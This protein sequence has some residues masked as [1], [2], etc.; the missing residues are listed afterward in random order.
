METCYHTEAGPTPEFLI[1]VWGVAQ[2][3]AFLTHSQAM[4]MLLVQDHIFEDIALNLSSGSNHN[5]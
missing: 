2:E 5:C 3:F 1:Q 4:P